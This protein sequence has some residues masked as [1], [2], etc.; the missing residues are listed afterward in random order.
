MVSCSQQFSFKSL[1]GDHGWQL[2]EHGGEWRKRYQFINMLV[3]ADT[4]WQKQTN[5]ELATHAPMMIHV[6]GRTD[7]GIRITQ[8]TEFVDLE[9][10]KF[11]IHFEFPFN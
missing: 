1:F 8:C 11:A 5:F 6:P 9:W 10:L 4:E 7:N 2:G 3:I